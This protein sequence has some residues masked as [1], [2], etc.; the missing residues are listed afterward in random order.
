MDDQM[1]RRAGTAII[2]PM[3]D[4]GRDEHARA[5]RSG[6]FSFSQPIG[7][8]ALQD[9]EG[10][11]VAVVSMQEDHSPSWQDGLEHPKVLAPRFGTDL[12]RL[13][14][15]QMVGT[16][17]IHEGSALTWCKQASLSCL[18]HSNLLLLTQDALLC[19]TS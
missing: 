18:V 19:S 4:P 2:E 9:V 14:N 7:D 5:C 15:R 6:H 3:D 1:A 12:D 17:P 11:L 13:M 10:L 8:L 16:E